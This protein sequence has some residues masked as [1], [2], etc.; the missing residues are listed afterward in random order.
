MPFARF[1]PLAA[2]L[3]PVAAV[4]Q[5]TPPALPAAQWS[6]SFT[7]YVTRLDANQAGVEAVYTVGPLAPINGTAISTSGTGAGGE[8]VSAN[9]SANSSTAPSLSASIYTLVPQSS[10][11]NYYAGGSIDAT[12]NYSF[13]IRHAAGLQQN[14][15]VDINAS[16]H[17]ETSLPGSILYP[18]VH[19]NTSQVRASLDI[20]SANQSRVFLGQI[21]IN[22]E[23]PNF[24]P[25]SYSAITQD[26][27]GYHSAF[28]LNGSYTLTTNTVYNVTM[29]VSAH[30]ST[31]AFY[32]GGSYLASAFV[33]PQ[34]SV[35]SLNLNSQDY[36]VEFSPGLGSQTSAVPDGGNTA[37]ILLP[38]LC[39]M[40]FLCR[41]S[42]D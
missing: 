7:S 6:G 1:L 42:R 15:Q 3:F 27:N 8:F 22:N 35:S 11:I 13:V 5:I 31:M 40:G 17:A 37:I 10:P 4:A 34:I 18:N 36:S 39:A 23:A 33:D 19:P 38:I 9:F 2:I 12:L 32:G 21:Y 25:S 28:N 26:S 41:R 24:G 30:S 29:N 16:G 14:V 20:I